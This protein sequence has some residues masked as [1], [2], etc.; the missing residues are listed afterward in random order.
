MIP[1][2]GRTPRCENPLTV[3]PFSQNPVLRSAEP[4]FTGWKTLFCGAWL[5]GGRR[6]ATL[7]CGRVYVK[8]CCKTVRFFFRPPAKRPSSRNVFLCGKRDKRDNVTNDSGGESF[9]FIFI[10]Y[11]YIYNIIYCFVSHSCLSHC[12]IVTL[13]RGETKKE[14]VDMR[15]VSLWKYLYEFTKMFLTLCSVALTSVKK[16]VLKHI[17][18][19]IHNLLW[20]NLQFILISFLRLRSYR[21]S[22]FRRFPR[23]HL[24]SCMRNVTGFSESSLR[25][26]RGI[27]P[28]IPQARITAA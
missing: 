2:N 21:E 17:Q 5:F 7:L 23:N 6:S 10:L 4:R 16:R 27:S 28:C 15:L 20:L 22:C 3:C 25:Q 18:S 19:H 14:R 13:S 8:E 24:T 26:S 11:I 12:H 1:K 9:P